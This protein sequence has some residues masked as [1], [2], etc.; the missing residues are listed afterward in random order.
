MTLTH[1]TTTLTF[2]NRA[3]YHIANVDVDADA[4]NFA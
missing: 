3:W 4:F 2:Y 1:N